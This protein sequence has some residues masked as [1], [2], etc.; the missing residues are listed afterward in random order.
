MVAEPTVDSVYSN[1]PGDKD[2]ENLR[3]YF[4]FWLSGIVALDS[5][6]LCVVI[7]VEWPVRQLLIVWHF[8]LSLASGLLPSFISTWCVEIT[9]GDLC[10]ACPVRT[11]SQTKSWNKLPSHREWALPLRLEHRSGGWRNQEEGLLVGHQRLL[12]QRPTA[13]LLGPEDREHLEKDTLGDLGNDNMAAS[14]GTRS[15][16]PVGLGSFPSGTPTRERLPSGRQRPV[17]CQKSGPLNS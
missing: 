5:L 12:L 6:Q 15:K 1:C 8:R 11:T 3:C 2:C 10:L 9:A 16:H 14:A 4:L 17:P 7:S 13:V